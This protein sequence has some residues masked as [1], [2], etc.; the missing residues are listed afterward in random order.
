[1][2]AKFLMFSLFILCGFLFANSALASI[3]WTPDAHTVAL[4]HLDGN[5]SDSSGN[6]LDLVGY[7][8]PTFSTGHFGMAIDTHPPL[9][10]SSSSYAYGSVDTGIGN[11]PITMV[12]SFYAA[13]PSPNQRQFICNN[14]FSSNKLVYRIEYRDISG[15]QYLRF[16]RDRYNI[17]SDYVSYTTTLTPGIY[18]NVILVYD[19]SVLKGYLNGNLVA[20]SSFS[21]DGGL[22]LHDCIVIGAE[23]DPDIGCSHVVDSW[24]LDGQVDEVIIQNTAWSDRDVSNYYNNYFLGSAPIQREPVVIVPGIMGS[25]LNRVSNGEEVWPNVTK[26]LGLSDT[27]L[28]DLRLSSSGKEIFGKE[29]NAPAVIEEVAILGVPVKTVYKNLIQDLSGYTL[30]T[31]LF[32]VPYDWRLDI[33][34]QIDKLDQVVNRAIKN[35][36]NGKINIIAH[37]MG[38]LLAKDYISETPTSSFLDKVIFLG[39]PNLGAPLAAKILNYGDDL[40]FKIIKNNKLTSILNEGE[41]KKISQNMPAVYELLPSRNYFSTVNSYIADFN[42]LGQDNFLD[43]NA[44]EQFLS[45][46][47]RNSGLLA[48]ADTFH[49]QDTTLVNAPKVYNIVGCQNYNTIGGYLIYPHGRYDLGY[50]SG[51]GTVPLGSAVSIPNTTLTYYA[52]FGTTG[53][54]HMGLAGDSN[55]LNIIQGILKDNPLSSSG[56]VTEDGTTCVQGSPDAIIFETHSPVSLNVYDHEGNH[57]GPTASGTTEFGITGA[58]YYTIEHNS[59]ARVPAGDAYTVVLNGTAT[60]TAEF[61][62]ESASGSTIHNKAVFRNIPISGSDT[63]VRTAFSDFHNQITL[64]V[65]NNGD[66]STDLILQPDAI[67]SGVQSADITPPVILT[68]YVSSTLV[69]GSPITLEFSAT[70]DLSGVAS[71]TATLDGNPVPNG[72]KISTLGVGQHTFEVDSVDN[73]GNPSASQMIFNVVYNFGGFLPPVKLDGSGTYKQG[74]TLPMKFQLTDA[75]GNFITNATARL[76]LSRVSDNLFGT[77]GDAY[78]SS[79]MADGESQFRYDFTTNQYVFNLPLNIDIGLWRLEVRLDDGTKHFVEISVK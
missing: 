35:S 59:F 63:V 40:N 44:T 10:T 78:L 56:N 57:L 14:S 42:P 76:S 22:A 38:G 75:N 45:G 65:D 77:T 26:M 36:P 25:Y 31:N 30:N 5:Y 71:T 49:E 32:V 79:N 64:N 43:Y 8:S 74:R 67:L 15:I 21:G 61:D 2:K 1:M 27:Y 73:A 20:S 41:I 51:D 18:Y 62:I 60:G 16:Y 55:V 54:D 46:Q 70:D 48:R 12:C 33:H 23:A 13:L 53:I 28:D 17:I 7:N 52:P 68:S 11:G 3:E 37:S 69:V 72:M 19:G 34:S 39:T 6:G 66:D 50:I 47:G 58:S 4:Y 24:G 9:I 29:M